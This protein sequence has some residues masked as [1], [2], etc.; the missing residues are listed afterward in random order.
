MIS[1]IIAA[2]LTIAIPQDSVPQLREDNIKEIVSLM[3]I[4]E[5][6]SL[7]I[8]G[9]NNNFNGIGYVNS[10]V[11]GAAGVINCNDRFQETRRLHFSVLHHMT[12][13]LAEPDR[14]M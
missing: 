1:L 9:R 12:L 7:I 2:I 13:S 11:P 10:G 6:C 8:G 4:D 3:T 5:K 14:V